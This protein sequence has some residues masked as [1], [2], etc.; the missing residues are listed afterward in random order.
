MN[1]IF[2]WAISILLGVVILFLHKL[3]D[4]LRDKISEERKNNF[5]HELQ[6]EAYFK[7]LGGKEQ[8]ELLD[9]WSRILTY[10][11]PV[12]DP[13]EWKELM[14][15]TI[16]YGSTKTINILSVMSQYSYNH[17]FNTEENEDVLGK[18]LLYVAFMIC[19]LKLDFS[20]QHL[21]PL[22]L[23]KI[24]INDINTM[25]KTYKKWIKEAENEIGELDDKLYS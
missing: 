1:D 24:K 14:H 20:G 8:K 10:M 21:D 9:K 15:E 22:V 17:D 4:M 7:E 5:A 13:E 11:K 12:E 6:V 19:S 23:L 18:Y 3:P 25:E 16:V 2:G